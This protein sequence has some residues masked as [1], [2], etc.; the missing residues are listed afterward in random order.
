MAG[1]DEVYA[2][3]KEAASHCVSITPADSS[4]ARHSLVVILPPTLVRQESAL[5]RRNGHVSHFEDESGERGIGKSLIVVNRE[6]AER[7][8][9]GDKFAMIRQ[10]RRCMTGRTL[11]RGM[12]SPFSRNWKVVTVVFSWFILSFLPI[13]C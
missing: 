8:V 7:V 10:F 5:N 13:G 9:A 3:I 12:M 6:F 11:R 4:K 2:G 1:M